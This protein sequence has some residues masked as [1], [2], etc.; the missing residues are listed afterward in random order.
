MANAVAQY[1][2]TKALLMAPT[3]AVSPF[4]YFLLVWAM[5]IGFVVW[6]DVPTVELLI[7]SGIVVASGLFLLWHEARRRAGQAKARPRQASACGSALSETTGR[8]A[9]EACSA[10]TA[11]ENR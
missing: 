2:W 1:A 8:S 6:G 11:G 4:Y 9:R 7:G 10:G 3:T 5:A